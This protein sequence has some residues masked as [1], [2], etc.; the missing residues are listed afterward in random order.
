[1]DIVIDPARASRLR[2]FARISR[3][4][5]DTLERETQAIT[6]SQAMTARFQTLGLDPIGGT[7]ADFRRNYAST[8]PVLANLVKVSG[9]KAE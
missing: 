3:R 4:I 8:A 2:A 1:M 6:R 9:A 7:A 5:L